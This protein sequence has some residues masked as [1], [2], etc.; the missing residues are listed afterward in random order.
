MR[1]SIFIL[2]LIFLSTTIFLP[3]YW[4]YDN[5]AQYKSLFHGV[6]SDGHAW[7][8]AEKPVLT[9]EEY[10]D[11][12]C[13]QCYKMHFVLRKLITQFP[14]KIRLV[15]RHYPIDNEVNRYVAPQPYHVGSGRLALLSIAAGQQGK[16]WQMNDLIYSELRNKQTSFD[17]KSLAEITKTDFKQ[18]IAD[19]QS[20]QTLK[21]LENDIKAGL[22]H[23]ISGT[24]T[25]VIDDAVYAGFIPPE[26]I[27]KISVKAK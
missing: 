13:F 21:V 7:I 27:E 18:L 9:I 25:Y 14:D 1:N 26:I 6:T 3:E 24:P 15:H 11:Y 5:S 22:R 8:G 16:F 4:K 12:Q 19:I 20:Q 2:S 17:L 23:K 10:T